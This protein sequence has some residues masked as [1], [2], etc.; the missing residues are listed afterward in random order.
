MKCVTGGYYFA[1]MFDSIICVFVVEPLFKL[2]LFF[3]VFSCTWD[4]SFY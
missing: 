1:S 4:F 2:I 3:L